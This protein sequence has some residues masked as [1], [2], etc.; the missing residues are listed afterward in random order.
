MKRGPSVGLLPLYLALYDKSHPA[1]RDEFEPFV[2]E[3]VSRFRSAGI[4]VVRA[5]PCRVDAEFRTAV[6]QFVQADV[7][8]IVTVHLA[9]SPSLEAVGALRRTC[10]E[11]CQ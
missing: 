6:S 4:E 2:A 10:R 1:L 7:D 11:L 3:I 9:Y 5:E 8:L